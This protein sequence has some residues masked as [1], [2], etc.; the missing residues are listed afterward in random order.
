MA[1]AHAVGTRSR[2]PTGAA[3]CSPNAASSP[4]RGSGSSRC[5]LPMARWCQ[6]AVGSSI[7]SAGIG[8]AARPPR[9]TAPRLPAALCGPGGRRWCS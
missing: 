3:T 5:R 2:R 7:P 1:L 4:R 9:T 6:S 8:S